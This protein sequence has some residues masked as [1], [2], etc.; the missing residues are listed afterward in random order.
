MANVAGIQGIRCGNHGKARVY[1]LST[2][3]VRE[4]FT[5]EPEPTKRPIRLYDLPIFGRMWGADGRDLYR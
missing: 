4:C 1:H 3:Q 2:E 5:P